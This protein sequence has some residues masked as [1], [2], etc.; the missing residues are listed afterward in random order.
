MRKARPIS[1]QNS[2]DV[3]NHVRQKRIALGLSQ[4]KLAQAVGIT[5]QAI[6]AIEAVQYSPATSVALRLARA[7]HC[8][9]EELFSLNDGG[10]L[11][12]GEWSG[13]FSEPAARVRICRVVDRTVIRP[14]GAL[15]GLLNFNEPADGTF[16]ASGKNRKRAKVKLLRDR[17]V[18][19]RQIAVAGC[20]PAMFLAGEYLRS[21][22][23]EGGL[24]VYLA[25]NETALAAL[26]RGDVH[27]AGIHIM[28][29]R[30]GEFNL[31]YLQRHLKDR[32]YLVTTF[33][34]W[35][36]G[37]IVAP[38]NPKRLHRVDDLGQRGIRLVNRESGSGARQLLDRRLAGIGLSP[39][40]LHGYQRI[41][42][43]HI[44]VGWCVKQGLADVGM[45][46]RAVARALGLDF[47]PLQL[48][49]Y[50]LVIPKAYLDIHPAVEVLLDIIVSRSFRAELE[51]L[52]G[53]DTCD[54]GKIWSI[55]A[56]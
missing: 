50:D 21:R 30:S 39:K 40:G 22:P 38:G 11:S 4:E 6:G 41:V 13:D 19:D 42:G 55:R 34:S 26:K 33:A 31:P 28:D 18:V 5:R 54:T 17:R 56:A 29:E 37:L 25:G 35:E 9:V 10:E 36:E 43:S 15:G 47:V 1:E 24:V 7:L 16:I 32:E 46:V 14:V 48:E 27:L 8:R 52:G 44:E 2:T 23:H 45:G 20:N 49:R 53:Y 12:E 3:E 51:A